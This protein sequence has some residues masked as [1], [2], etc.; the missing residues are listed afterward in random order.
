[1]SRIQ[2]NAS[3]SSTFSTDDGLASRISFGRSTVRAQSINL[4]TPKE[5]R[6]QLVSVGGQIEKF[7]HLIDPAAWAFSVAA[8]LG[9]KQFL[10]KQGGGCRCG[11]KRLESRW[12]LET[13][14]P[15]PPPP[16]PPPRSMFWIVRAMPSV[17]MRMPVRRDVTSSKQMGRGRVVD[18]ESG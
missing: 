11:T 9:E 4:R 13:T 5:A 18:R 3:V 2:M 15:P 10:Q 12:V 8:P 14:P 16:P 1:M 17:A 7:D 6:D